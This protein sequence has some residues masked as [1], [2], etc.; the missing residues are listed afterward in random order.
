MIGAKA[1]AH[2]RS[3]SDGSM[4][5]GDDLSGLDVSSLSTSTAVV[6]ASKD[7]VGPVCWRARKTGPLDCSKLAAID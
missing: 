5:T 4:S 7:S 1:A 6:R 3:R 2:E